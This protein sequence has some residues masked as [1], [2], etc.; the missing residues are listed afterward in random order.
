MHILLQL[1]F[2]VFFFNKYFPALGWLLLYFLLTCLCINPCCQLKFA[3]RLDDCAAMLSVVNRF[4]PIHFV[5]VFFMLVCFR[6]GCRCFMPLH[7]LY[8][9]YKCNFNQLSFGSLLTTSTFL[10][11]AGSCCISYWHVHVSTAVV[12]FNLPTYWMI[13]LQCLL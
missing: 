13:V 1:S 6:R 11:W 12:N 5:A 2:C 9:K 4:V 7:F 8:C 10:P 3:H